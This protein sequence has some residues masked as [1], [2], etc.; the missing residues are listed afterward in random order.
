MNTQKRVLEEFNKFT[1][2]QA[3]RHGQFQDAIQKDSEIAEGRLNELESSLKVLEESASTNVSQAL[4][5]FE[6]KYG[7]DL[8][9]RSEEIDANIDSW[10][11]NFNSK[12]SIL[13]ADEEENRR[14]IEAKYV[15]DLRAHTSGLQEKTRETLERYES[16]IK[17]T[18]DDLQAQIIEVEQKMHDFREKNRTDLEAATTNSDSFIKKTLTTYG[19]RLNELLTK[20]TDTN[21]SKIKDLELDLLTRSEANKANIDAMVGDFRAWSTQL[22][23]QFEQSKALYG[24]KF[25]NINKTAEQ[26][27]NELKSKFSADFEEFKRSANSDQEEITGNITQLK[28]MIQNSIANFKDESEKLIA[29]Q[30]KNYQKILSETQERINSQNADSANAVREIQAQIAHMKDQLAEKQGETIMQMNNNVDA[31]QS[32]FSEIDS[33]VKT[34]EA[35][36]QIYQKADELQASLEKQIEGIKNELGRIET[37]R[38]V[39]TDLENQFSN[40]QKINGDIEQ[41]IARFTAEKGQID[42]IERDFNRLVSLSDNM[43]QKISELQTTNSDLQSLQLTVRSFHESLDKISV[44]CDSLDKKQAILEQISSE[45]DKTFDN[46]KDV[47]GRLDKIQSQAEDLP[48][49]ISNIQARIDEI[50]ENSGKINDAVEQITSLQKLL[51]ETEKRTEEVK[52]AKEGIVNTEIR[53]NNLSQEINEKFDILENITRNEVEASVAA[54]GTTEVGNAR[55]SPKDKEVIISLK[56]QGWTVDEIAKR[57]KR[58][59][60]E[61]EM[62]IEMGL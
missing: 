32:R 53:L 2:E 44:R 47:E 26:A 9:R 36:M 8:R 61:V 30:Q 24:S 19:E 5:A 21:E 51:A 7:E 58:S 38:S 4:A 18:N 15:E 6:K 10:R 39:V 31:L 25:E 42:S 50:T 46:L 20:F 27:L 29:E 60:G 34:F 57:L 3:V 35:R 16:M 49:T 40:I 17:K 28:D 45:V 22:N 23:N 11:E 13:Q 37:Y 12:M 52:K 56:R 14:Q 43:D 59:V 55:L 1:E 41:K 48:A 54:S 33:Q 62:V